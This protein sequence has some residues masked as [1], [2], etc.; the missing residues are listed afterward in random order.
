MADDR[1]LHPGRIGTHIHERHGLAAARGRGPVGRGVDRQQASNNGIHRLHPGCSGNRWATCAQRRAW[2][3]I[4]WTSQPNVSPQPGIDRDRSL[5]S[6]KPS[7][8]GLGSVN[9]RTPGDGRGADGG[10]AHGDKMPFCPLRCALGP[11][12]MVFG[13]SDTAPVRV[14]SMPLVVRPRCGTCG[15]PG[16]GVLAMSSPHSWQGVTPDST[17]GNVGIFE[18]CRARPVGA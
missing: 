4:A 18:W 1:G 16:S 10:D 2:T 12:T 3:H 14:G 15:P 8:Y 17:V 5:R 13:T 6:S 9:G 11:V 7:R